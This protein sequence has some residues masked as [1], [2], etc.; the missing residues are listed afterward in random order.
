MNKTLQIE[1]DPYLCA[2]Q[3]RV[4]SGKLMYQ[5]MSR[6]H[7][8]IDEST[9]DVQV[10]IEFAREGKF[11][12]VTGRIQGYLVLQCAACLEALH[13]PIDIDVRLAVINDEALVTL[14]P[15]GF[16]PKIFDGEKLV[17]SELIEDELVLAMPDIARHDVCPVKLPNSSTSKD[18]V[19]ELDVKENPFKALEGFKKN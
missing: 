1:I 7:N 4:F 6:I 14:I 2:D 13:F 11:I 18:F 16:E 19:E 9:P 3:R 10:D 5:E 17:L 12:V 15:K 8:D